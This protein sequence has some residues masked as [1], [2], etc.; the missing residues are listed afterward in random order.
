MD[1]VV[2]LILHRVISQ[3][4]FLAFFINVIQRLGIDQIQL[5][6]FGC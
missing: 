3:G 2:F 5:R 4:I 1:G 6:G